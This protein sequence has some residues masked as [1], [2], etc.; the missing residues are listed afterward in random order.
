M[1][2]ILRPKKIGKAVPIIA[3]AA[4]LTVVT[5][6][7]D[8]H[9]AEGKYCFRWGCVGEIPSGF[10][11]LNSVA[12][13]ETSGDKRRFRKLLS[14]AELAPKS[15][16]S[17][18]GMLSTSTQWPTQRLLLRPSTHSRSEG[19]FLCTSPSDLM[20]AIEDVKQVSNKYYISE[21]VQK[22]REYRVFCAFGRVAWVIEKHP[23]S[24]EDVS[25]GCVSDGSFDYID[26]S[27]WPVDVLKNALA[28]MKLSGL[29]YGAVDI[30]ED[31]Q[32]R[33]YTLEINTAPY[34]TP[35]Y[36]KTIAKVFKYTEENGHTHF[37]DPQGETW[38]AFIHKGVKDFT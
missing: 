14:D 28:S 29:D 1:S 20:K 27:D 23:K 7:E 10:K 24:A 11:S 32:K 15:W 4:D 5:S 38:K 13:Q 21:F 37:G 17:L 9:P 12:A 34:L 25:W 31:E 33:V 6:G 30:I 8:Q 26:W 3:E 36:A 35:Y 22:K 18:E 16:M 2:Y 19:M